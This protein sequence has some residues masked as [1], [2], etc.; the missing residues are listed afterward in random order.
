MNHLFH[1]DPERAATDT[2]EI[3]TP[4]VAADYAAT[5]GRVCNNGTSG[6]TMVTS[7]HTAWPGFQGQSTT[8]E[9]ATSALRS[10]HNIIF[11]CR[12]CSGTNAS[13]NAATYAGHFMVLTGVDD[14]AR[15]FNVIDPAGHNLVSIDRR[16]L[17]QHAAGFWLVTRKPGLQ[18]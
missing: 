10:G 6:Q 4:A 12:N 13:G 18:P 1:E 9:G 16:E 2:F 11:L 8:L 15:T 17:Q 3:V 7:V 5:H 14:A